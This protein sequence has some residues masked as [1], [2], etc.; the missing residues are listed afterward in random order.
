MYD[1]VGTPCDSGSV[2]RG[3]MPEWL[4]GTVSK[5]VEQ[6]FCSEGSNPSLSAVKK[7]AGHR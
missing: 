2:K 5:T 1:R 4:N 7:L 3:E 6:V